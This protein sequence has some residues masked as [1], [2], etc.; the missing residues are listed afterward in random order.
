MHDTAYGA[1]FQPASVCSDTCQER[2]VNKYQLN[3]MQPQPDASARIGK[4][5]EV[6]CVPIKG[7]S[8][9]Y[10]SSHGLGRSQNQVKGQEARETRMNM[11]LTGWSRG[12]TIDSIIAA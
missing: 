1:A 6:H 4:L 10:T 5:A 12:Q 3:I 2:T 8:L 9:P 11:F 7:W